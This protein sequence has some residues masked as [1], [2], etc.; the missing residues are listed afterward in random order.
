MA[1]NKSSF[2]DGKADLLEMNVALSKILASLSRV[3]DP[4]GDSDTVENV[5]DVI[6]TVCS[7]RIL[8]RLHLRA[9]HKQKI[10]KPVDETLKLAVTSL[11][12]LRRKMQ[13]R[14]EFTDLISTFE[15]RANEVVKLVVAWTKH[16][17]TIRL[18]DLVEG[19]HNIW[20]IDRLDE[21]L[22]R[23]PNTLMSPNLRTSLRNIISKVARYKEAARYL[24]RK[25]RRFPSLR[26]A[27]IVPVTL[28]Q[29]MFAKVE[30]N[31]YSP[32][33]IL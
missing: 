29:Q 12:Q 14:T 3:A 21:L 5:L 23:I 4:G 13:N 8:G 32:S 1:V 7:E 6:M 9:N 16:Q 30:V 27:E 22:G 33:A 20:M 10:K 18:Q 25:A 31:H 28:Q 24:Y 15:T 19:I 2:E 11:R 17:T 26:R